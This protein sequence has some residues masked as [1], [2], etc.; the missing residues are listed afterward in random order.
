M[1][2]HVSNES[3][4]ALKLQEGWTLADEGKDP[5]LLWLLIEA[6]HRVGIA[7]RIPAVLKAESRRAYQACAQSTYESIVVFKERFD[8]LL[9]SYEEHGNPEMDADDVAMDFYRALDN[10]RYAAFK[11]SMVNNINSGAIEQPDTLNEM[12]TQAAAYL[13]PTK[14]GHAGTHRTAFATTADRAYNK[15]RDKG[16]G[17]GDKRGGRGSSGRGQKEPQPRLGTLTKT[18]TAGGVEREDTSCACALTSRRLTTKTRL[19][20]RRT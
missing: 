14:Q 7:S 11:T 8:D 10:S 17:G 19:G 6:T 13:I 12:Y 2:L 15:G 18:E 9:S 16:G 3:L 5:L 20:D 1:L 4:D